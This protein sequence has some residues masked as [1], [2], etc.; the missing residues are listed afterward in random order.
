MMRTIATIDAG[1]PLLVLGGIGGASRDVAGALG[2]TDES[3]R[4]FRQDDSYRD[5]DGCP[6]ARAYE[7]QLDEVAARRCAYWAMLEGVGLTS[8]AQ[9]LALSESHSEIGALFV[10]ILEIWLK[11][12]PYR[13]GS[14]SVDN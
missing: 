8:E 9:R 4:V 12:L 13:S 14:I 2:L 1:K 5:R 6:S 3:E 10:K 7:A 11:Q